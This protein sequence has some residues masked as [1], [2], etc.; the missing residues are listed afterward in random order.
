MRHPE[1]PES[2]GELQRRAVHVVHVDDVVPRLEQPHEHRAHRPHPRRE[3]PAG[4]TP[5]QGREL[6]LHRL[7]GR[8]LAPAVDVMV[9]LGTE[10]PHQVVQGLVCEERR[11]DDGRRQGPALG[12]QVLFVA[13]ANELVP[14]VDGGGFQV[15]HGAN[16]GRRRTGW[17]G[18]PPD[19]PA[20]AGGSTRP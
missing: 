15:D 17:R 2:F 16:L 1:A 4:L 5:L 3:A 13:K 10:A 12:G 19:P 14:G 6:L 18:W 20:R 9:V 7:P 11:L 8:V